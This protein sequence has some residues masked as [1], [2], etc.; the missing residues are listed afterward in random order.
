MEIMSDNK[1]IELHKRQHDAAGVLADFQRI[2]NEEP[3]CAS[4]GVPVL[5][6]SRG[7]SGDRYDIRQLSSDMR[8]MEAV[9]LLEAAKYDMLKKVM[10]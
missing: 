7:A 2:L 9:A 3:E 1:V 5:M 4:D 8:Y 10:G 6:L